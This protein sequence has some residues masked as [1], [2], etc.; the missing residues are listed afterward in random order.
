MNRNYRPSFALGLAL[1]MG[2]ALVAGSPGGTQA[3]AGRAGPV[4]PEGEMR[5]ALYV[6]L[7]PAWFDP[8]EVIGVLT[9]FWVLYA[10]HDALVKPMPGNL[11]APSLAESWTTSPDQ[12]VYDFKLRE[13]L[14]FH[15]G[16]PFTAEDVK[17]S[18]H[19]AK[20]AKILQDK[21][22]DV[23]VVDPHRIRFVLHEP[24][25][26]FMTFYGTL[27]TSAGW[28]A[29]KKYMEQVGVEGF[30]KQPVGLGPYR[31]VSHTPGVELVMEAFEG[32]WRKVPSVK[33]LVY[34]SVPEATT[35]LAMLKRGEVDLAY[36]LDGPMAEEVKRDP[37]L[38]LAF[39][40]AIGTFYLDFLEQWDAKS[41]WHDR[42]VRL[43]AS[44]AIDR[45]TLSTAETLGASRLTGNI[46]PRTFEG[47]I[48][49]DAHPYDPARAKQLLAEAGYPNGFD[50]GDL[51]PWPP[52][53]SMG[54]AVAG[55]L[56]A[57]G[58]KTRMRTMERAAFYAA[59]ASK[60]LKGLC[61]CINAVY[62]N[63]ASRMAQTVPGDGAYAYGAYPDI[64]A[65]Y[66]QQA[67]ETDRRKRDALL[68]QIQ[69]LLHERVRFAAIYDYIWP[70]GVGPRVEEPA[71]M[72]IDPYPWSA[73]LEEVRL[74]RR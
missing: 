3:Q 27:A 8:A 41:P 32:Y 28:I 58:I 45:S 12:R 54:E 16:D 40:G 33:R 26:D 64:E 39:S 37:T 20:G 50:A 38:K 18:F 11:L 6:T 43:A 62:G 21:V 67:R 7:A 47:A 13:G 74:K 56:G 70:S 46:V 36:L 19:R 15:N 53:T 57:V 44:L 4:Q 72:L 55:Y 29:P 25:P 69:Q 68:A 30:K 35:R 34:K 59:L 5:W 2:A 60:K 63:A 1:L 10:M 31:F 71:L 42:R 17:F 61:L 52:Y 24:W 22:R 23:T 48:P 73:P 65:L 51:Y 9:P 14:K 66:S 49:I